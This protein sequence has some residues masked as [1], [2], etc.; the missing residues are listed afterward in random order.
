MTIVRR[1]GNKFMHTLN[2]RIKTL[3][4]IVN[5]AQPPLLLYAIR[6]DVVFLIQWEKLEKILS[7]LNL[8]EDFYEY[9]KYVQNKNITHWLKDKNLL[10]K[11]ILYEISDFVTWYS[12]QNYVLLDKLFGVNSLNALMSFKSLIRTNVYNFIIFKHILKNSEKLN[13]Y[14]KN[15]LN[16][17]KKNNVFE[18][19]K[20]SFQFFMNCLFEVEKF[21]LYKEFS[22]NE[23]LDIC[24]ES[25]NMDKN[26]CIEKISIN[27][28][29]FYFECLK[30]GLE[31]D[32]ALKVYMENLNKKNIADYF[33]IANKF[34]RLRYMAE[35]KAES[36]FLK[37]NLRKICSKALYKTLSFCDIN[38][39][40]Y[41]ALD[42]ENR[43]A[44]EEMLPYKPEACLFG[45]TKNKNENLEMVNYADI[46]HCDFS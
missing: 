27:N 29:D 32:F 23:K 6:K 8:S 11:E 16:F 19:K 28:D 26:F 41:F 34:T 24:C 3:S 10:T 4:P 37:Q 36:Q 13:K 39:I 5:F 9:L 33:E 46:V 31:L 30:D 12:P 7:V 22:L 44:L 40:F 25:A 21:R 45:Y 42:D 18:H 43:A 2:L 35:K 14:V 20:Y 17:F 38:Q 15:L 1:R